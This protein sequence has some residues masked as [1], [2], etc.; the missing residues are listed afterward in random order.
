MAAGHVLALERGRPGRRYILGNENLTLRGILELLA[1]ITGLPAPRVRIPH[2]VAIGVAAVDEAVEG[3]IL[4]RP[5]AA[6]LDG[7]LMARKHMFFTAR[8]AVHELGLPQSPVRDALADA[9]AWYLREGY[10]PA[11]PATRAA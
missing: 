6:P 1:E 4:R 2:A 3:R 10:A 5:P 9:V 7:A 8:R 11:P